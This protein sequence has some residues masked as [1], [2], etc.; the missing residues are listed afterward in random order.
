MENNDVK[1]E[2]YREYKYIIDIFIHKYHKAALAL[3]IDLKELEGEAHLAFSDA[4]NS[5]QDNKKTKLSTFI[6]LCIDRRIK[7][8]LKKYSTEKAHMLN[9]AYSLD[10]AYF[11]EGITLK[12]I[13]SDNKENDPLNNLTIKENYQELLKKIKNT[14]SLFEYEVF[15]YYINGIDYQTIAKI[16]NKNPKQIDNTIQRIKHKIKDIYQG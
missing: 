6:S 2:L 4:I 7:N 12:D 15:C 11:E 14:L 3:N 8:L 16:I 9:N 5:Y 10:Y 13:I 1:D